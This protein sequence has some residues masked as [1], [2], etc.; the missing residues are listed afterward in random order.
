MGPN[1]TGAPMSTTHLL[2]D[3]TLKAFAERAPTYDAKNQF[4]AE[5]FEDMRKARYLVAPIPKELGGLG[6]TLEQ[7]C[8]EQRRLAYHA[9][10]TALAINMHVF[11]LG[12]IADL[13]RSG[14]KSLEWV[15]KEG[16]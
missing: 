12:L 14:D 16:A 2:S 4:F 7:M 8:L 10:A 9:P 15:L 11:W 13:W 1:N 5:D 3:Q 6:Y